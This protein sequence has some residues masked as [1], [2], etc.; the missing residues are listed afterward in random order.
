VADDGSVDRSTVIDVLRRNG[1]EISVMADSPDMFFI[2]KGDVFEIIT[3]PPRCRR[4]LV[5]YFSRKFTTPIH[6]FYNPGM[7][8]TLPDETVQ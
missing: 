4:R 6:H 5:H 7:A 8:P 1:S 3:I 2:I